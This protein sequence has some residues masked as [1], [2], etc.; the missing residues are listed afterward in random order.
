MAT[1]IKCRPLVAGRGRGK[2]LSTQQNISFWGGIDPAS[3]MIIDPR[4]ELFDQ[5]ITS[6]VLAFP[7]GKG[8]AAAPLVLLELAKQGAAPAAIINIEIDPLLVA[9]PIISKHFYGTTIPVVA[10]PRTAFD[11][12]Q[13]GQDATVDSIKGEIVIES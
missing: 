9:G 8:S 12:L 5:P 3:G 2:I 7:Y 10:L 11:Q 6:K 4:H 1:T 13:T